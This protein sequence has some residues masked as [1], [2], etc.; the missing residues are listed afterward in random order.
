MSL[1]RYGELGGRAGND[2]RN[3]PRA[4]IGGGRVAPGTLAFLACCRR[5][6][7]PRSTGMR[8]EAKSCRAGLAMKIRRWL[9]RDRR[10][11]SWCA[12]LLGW[13]ADRLSAREGLKDEHR[14]AAVQ[15]NEARLGVVD[16]GIAVGGLRMDLGPCME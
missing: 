8:C 3:P 7:E 11:Q 9:R 15:A 10:M 13:C 14:S 12:R 16:L 2:G 5:R 6:L 1:R 4:T